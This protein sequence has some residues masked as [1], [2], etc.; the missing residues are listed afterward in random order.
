MVLSALIK[1]GT[2]KHEYF[3]IDE[4]CLLVSVAMYAGYAIDYLNKNK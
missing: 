3:D 4:D 2:L 1:R